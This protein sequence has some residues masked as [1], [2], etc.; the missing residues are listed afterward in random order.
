MAV[1]RGFDPSSLMEYSRL[2]RTERID[3]DLAIETARKTG[4]EVVLAGRGLIGA[5]AAIPFCGRPV[6]SVRPGE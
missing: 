3:Y 1:Y 4:A 6:E 2:C 5:L